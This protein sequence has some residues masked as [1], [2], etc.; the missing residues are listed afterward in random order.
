MK[1]GIPIRGIFF[2]AG[3]TLFETKE[4]IG[5]YY[6]Q[7][8]RRYDVHFEADRLNPRFK[9]AFQKAPPLAF[10]DADKETLLRLEYEW[11]YGLVR[12]VFSEIKFPRFDDFFET[13]YRFFESAGPWKLFPETQAVLAALKKA[14]FRLGIISNFD[15]RLVSICRHLG[16]HRFFDLI[17]FSSKSAVAKP[18]P[19]IFEQSLK[20]LGLMSS[21]TLYVGDQYENDVVG[22]QSVGM[23]ALLI[24]REGHRLKHREVSTIRDLREVCVFIDSLL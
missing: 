9:S 4:T 10:P 19:E 3:N 8:A 2:D 24:E 20:Q 17:V 15:S 21:E 14:N 16:I 13:L 5:F 7:I 22:P 6:S 11:W 18:Q 23:K 1:Q 12:D